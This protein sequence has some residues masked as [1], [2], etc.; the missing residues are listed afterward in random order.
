MFYSVS[1]ADPARVAH[2]LAV[3][4]ILV[5]LETANA[6]PPQSVPI[7]ALAS[8]CHRRF[9][10]ASSRTISGMPDTSWSR[11]R[12]SPRLPTKSSARSAA[13]VAER[14]LRIA[15]DVIAHSRCYS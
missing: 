9:A 6:A 1:L 2:W 14:K 3:A 12:A 11:P 4:L 5:G 15:R 7:L 13:K 10:R 8:R